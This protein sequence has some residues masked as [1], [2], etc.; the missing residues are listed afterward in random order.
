MCSVFLMY[1]KRIWCQ[2]KIM[3]HCL[4][5]EGISRLFPASHMVMY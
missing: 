4:E 5:G 1:Q 2:I 3:E